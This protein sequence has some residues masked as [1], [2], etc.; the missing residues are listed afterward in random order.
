MNASRTRRRVGVWVAL[1]LIL[2]PCARAHAAPPD[3][4]APLTLAAAKAIALQRQPAIAAA[5]ASLDAAH[6]RK[7]SL[8]NLRVPLCLQPDL[9][10]RR[11][12][13]SLGPSA[14]EAGVLLAELNTLYGVEYAYVAYL[15]ARSQQ[16]VADDALRG[17]TELEQFFAEIVESLK[18]P[19]FSSE[20]NVMDRDRVRAM[21]RL[22]RARREEAIVG[23]QRALSALREALG[24]PEDCP[25]HLAHDRLLH[26][27]LDLNCQAL[28]DLALAHRPEIV[29]A[30]IAH[31]VHQLEV[32]AQQKNK[33]AL[34]AN[35]FAA[36][37]DLHAQPLP[38]GSYDADYKPQAVGPEMPV[39]LAGKSGDRARVAAIYQDRSLSVLEKTRNLIRLEVEQACLRYQ[40]ARAKL[41]EL[42]QGIQDATASVS[43]LRDQLR[44]AERNRRGFAEAVLN[45][46]I[47]GAQLRVAANEARFQLLVALIAL[48]RGTGGTFCAGIDNAPQ[49]ADRRPEAASDPSS[50]KSIDKSK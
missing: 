5:R 22:A 46:A 8:D 49:V 18:D 39:L 12:Q 6:A 1:T 19:K 41:L 11:Q 21:V 14:A 2:Y 43:G 27:D 7:Q 24:V 17:L 3:H 20:F 16:Q 44:T 50:K 33:R 40:E 10:L 9:P 4:L 26:V 42:E 31:Q 45:T 38:A 47:I 23:S 32:A 30:S 13:A 48:E 15:F 35:T 25:L 37:S 34:K 28:V 29:Q 36:G